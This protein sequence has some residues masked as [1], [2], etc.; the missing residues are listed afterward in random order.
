MILLSVFL[1]E[2]NMNR[3]STRVRLF[4]MVHHSHN[5]FF[6]FL[7]VLSMKRCQKHL[8]LSSMY[9]IFI[10]SSLTCISLNIF[11][12]HF[13]EY[14]KQITDFIGLEQ[15]QFACLVP[16]PD[17]NIMYSVWRIKSV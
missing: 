15:K 6:V 4:S 14:I 2:L 12:Q 5:M 13:H 17:M 3:V 8:C 9:S 10:F 1:D 11:F 7:H 16:L